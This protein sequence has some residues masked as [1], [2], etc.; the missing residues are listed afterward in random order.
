[1]ASRWKQVHKV[2]ESHRKK[3]FGDFESRKQAVLFGIMNSYM[4]V[5][6]PLYKYPLKKEQ[7]MYRGEHVSQRV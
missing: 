4:D 3:Q 2:E 6:Y 7:G 5:W 1:V